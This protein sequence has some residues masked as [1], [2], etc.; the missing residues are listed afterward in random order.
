MRVRAVLGIL[1]Y[2]L[3]TPVPA[4]RRP[5]LKAARYDF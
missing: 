5:R 4:L 1:M 2:Y 3:Y